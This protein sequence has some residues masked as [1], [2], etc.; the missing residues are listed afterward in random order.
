MVVCG[1]KFSAFH[2]GSGKFHAHSTAPTMKAAMNLTLM[3]VGLI[4]TAFSIPAG[5]VILAGYASDH[6]GRKAIMAPALIIYGLGP[7]LRCIGVALSSPI[8]FTAGQ[9][10]ARGRCRGTY[11]LAM[12]LTGDIFKA[13]SE[14]MPWGYWKP[15]MDWARW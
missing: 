8:I 6:L 9:S 12:A 1:I 11:Q 2:Y 3:Q 14:R 7:H 5:V 13:R 10:G 15:P 4:I